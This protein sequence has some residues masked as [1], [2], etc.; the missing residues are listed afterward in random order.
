MPDALTPLLLQF[1]PQNRKVS[2]KQKTMS[3][4]QFEEFAKARGFRV[5]PPDHPVYSEGPSIAL[6]SRTPKQSGQ[7]VVDTPYSDP[8]I[9]S[10]SQRSSET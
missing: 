3:R 2:M 7:R 5:A 10:E 4:K 9:G 6:L 8:P 1:D